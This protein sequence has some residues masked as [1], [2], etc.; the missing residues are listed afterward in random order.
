MGKKA[1]D[2][3]WKRIFAIR[4]ELRA[5]WEKGNLAAAYVEGH[6]DSVYCAQFDEYGL[7]VESSLLLRILTDSTVKSSSPV[8][9]TVPFVF[10]IYIPIEP[11]RCWEVRPWE[12]PMPPSHRLRLPRSEARAVSRYSVRQPRLHRPSRMQCPPR[13]PSITKHRSSAFNSIAS[14]S[15]PGHRMRRASSGR[16]GRI[17]DPFDVSNITRSASWTSV[18]TQSAS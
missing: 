18:W 12:S 9:V 16:S 15:S 8:P 7:H 4:K 1:P 3:D 11:S 13:H 5:K 17:I 6:T 10:G 2:Q 14:C